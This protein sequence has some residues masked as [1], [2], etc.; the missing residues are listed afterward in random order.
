MDFDTTSTETFDSHTETLTRSEPER[1]RTDSRRRFTPDDAAFTLREYLSDIASLPTLTREEERDLSERMQLNAERYR[2]ALRSIPFVGQ[3]IVARWRELRAAG[4]TSATLSARWRD[5]G[6]GDPAPQLDTALGRAAALLER[7]V[8][9]RAGREALA[10]H[11]IAADV[12]MS[13]YEDADRELDRALGGGGAEGAIAGLPARQLHSR[14]EEA[15]RSREEM[16]EAKNRFVR[17]NLKLVVHMAKGFRSLELPFMDLIQEGNMGLIRAVEKFDA[18]R[19]FK[20][21][22]YAAWWI[23]Q[24]FIRAA[25]HQSRTVRLPSHVY[26]FL[27]KEKRL[28]RSLEGS[29]GHEPTNEELAEVL[30]VSCEDVDTL[31]Q[32]TR[33]IAHLDTEARGREDTTLLDLLRHDTEPDPGQDLNDAQ[34]APRVASLLEGLSERERR[35][36][37]LRFGLEGGRTHTLQEVG[38][39]L[40]I[41]RE[42]VRQI[43]KGAL[44]RMLEPARSLGLQDAIGD[45]AARAVGGITLES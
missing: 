8:K 20:F 14:R 27:I 41:S 1:P 31:R 9:T 18:S 25:Q 24:S 40:G 42:R 29:L 38:T 21:S 36:V 28:R 17:H 35:V 39:T 34:I 23:R 22:T 12:S 16:L 19:G 13:V 7:G 10:E 43:E 3:A 2:A 26:D 11:L 37:I 32:A 33:P 6:A 45:D 15:R 5:P 44:E 4:R 30:G